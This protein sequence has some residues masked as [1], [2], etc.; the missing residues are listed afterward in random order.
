MSARGYMVVSL[1]NITDE[2]IQ[3]YIDSQEVEPVEDGQ[4]QIDSNL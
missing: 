3:E 4:F 2:M 1:G